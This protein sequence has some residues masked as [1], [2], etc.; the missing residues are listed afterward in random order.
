MLVGSN[1]FFND[2]LSAFIQGGGGW[3]EVDISC[4]RTGRMG[5]EMQRLLHEV[6]V[7]F[8]FW[9]ALHLVFS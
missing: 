8:Q 1:V 6:G 3:G 9:L 7:F 5:R 2:F 4:V